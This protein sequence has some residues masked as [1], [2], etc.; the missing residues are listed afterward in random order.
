MLQGKGAHL[1]N[2]T[3]LLWEHWNLYNVDS[4]G[5]GHAELR[6]NDKATA[7]KKEEQFKARSGIAVTMV[8]AKRKGATVLHNACD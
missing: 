2:C 5:A 3:I 7:R 1:L 6:V 4:S 8:P